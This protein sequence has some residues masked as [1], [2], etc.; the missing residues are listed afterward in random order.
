MNHPSNLRGIGFMLIAG[1]VFVLNDSFMKLLL[2]DFPPYEV[3]ALRGAFGMVIAG[4][5]LGLRGELQHWRTALN[6]FVFLRA[7]LE[8]AAIL[9]YILAL[10]HAPIG[11]VTAIFQTTPLLVILGM[12][13]IHRERASLWRMGL[14]I[15]GFGGALLVAQPGQG[16]ISPFVMLAFVTTIFAALRDLAGRH[17]PKDVP[18]LLSTLVTIVVVVIPSIFCG[19][20]FENW[21]AP[22]APALW[23]GF[24][25]GL[26]MML[27]HFFTLLAYKNASAQ[28]VAPF[29]Y[30]F[31]V[32]AVVMGFVIFGDVPNTLAFLGMAIIMGSG[33]AIAGLERKKSGV[34]D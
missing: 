4:S 5:F 25:A 31:M 34:A 30:S 24:G 33:L 12:V 21:A 18:P 20:I 23:L 6:R 26:F 22:K 14:V 13:F 27:G 3:L 28:A 7:G 8:A 16:T 32:F 17:I 9:T 10:A 2:A 11:D 1:F 29:Y 15:L 19:L